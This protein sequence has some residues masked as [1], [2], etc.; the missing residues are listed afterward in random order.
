[1][2]SHDMLELYLI[3]IALEKL[4]NIPE[5]SDEISDPSKCNSLPIGYS[6]I[7]ALTGLSV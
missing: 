3:R 1:M 4:D 5:G 7:V 6:V 2:M